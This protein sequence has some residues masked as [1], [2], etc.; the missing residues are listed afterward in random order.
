MVKE[1]I[2]LY[3]K[4]DE[5]IAT[6]AGCTIACHCGPNTLGILFIRK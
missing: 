6:K 3:T 5:I 2:A 4:F 1:N